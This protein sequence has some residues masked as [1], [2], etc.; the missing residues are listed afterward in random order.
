MIVYDGDNDNNNKS[1][2]SE[3]TAKE[4]SSENMM[5]TEKADIYSLGNTLY[6]LLTGTEP[7]GKERKRQRFK[8]VSEAVSRGEYP[9]FPDRYA[10]SADP[11]VVG[12][13][14]AILSCWEPDP[15][16]R[17]SAAEIARG[18]FG[19]LDSIK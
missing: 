19:V 10:D 9:T 1:T 14:R 13:R 12:I 2:S 3:K 11:A 8:S 17:P 5:I 16:V 15:R 7:R 4:H 18:L 6:V